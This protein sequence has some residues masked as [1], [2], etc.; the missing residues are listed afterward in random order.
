MKRSPDPHHPSPYHGVAQ[1][2][3]KQVY[4]T[5]VCEDPGKV[6]ED[7]IGGGLRGESRVS[8]ESVPPSSKFGGKVEQLGPALLTRKTCVNL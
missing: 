2:P 4:G 6:V 5:S 8:Y 3:S 1:K 7:G